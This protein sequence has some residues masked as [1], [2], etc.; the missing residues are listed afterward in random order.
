MSA[1]AH[2]AKRVVL[3]IAFV[4]LRKQVLNFLAFV[5]VEITFHSATKILG[6][7]D[8]QGVAARVPEYVH[9]G[10]LRKV[11]RK[12]NLGEVRTAACLNRLLQITERENSEATP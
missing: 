3:P 1:K 9:T 5:A 12:A 2:G 7:A 6:L 4:H 10:G 11:I 8:V